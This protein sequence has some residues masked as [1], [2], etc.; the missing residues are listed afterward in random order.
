MKLRITQCPDPMMWYAALVGK[1]V[2]FHGSWPG[3]GYKSTDCGGYTNV[4][5]FSDAE[6]IDGVDSNVEAVRSMLLSRSK[7]GLTKYGVTTERTDID[8]IGWLTHL[9]EELCDAAVYVARIKEE[10]HADQQ[11]TQGDSPSSA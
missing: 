9:Q 8:L 7:T 4:V 10:L 3:E 11:K 2:P 5:R 6:V 1:L